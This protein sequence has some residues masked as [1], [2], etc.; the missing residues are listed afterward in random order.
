MP[1]ALAPS[2]RA[3]LVAALVAALL[4]V[5]SLSSP[6]ADGITVSQSYAMPALGTVTFTGHGY[7]HGHGMSQY[8]AE[9]AAR[10]GLTWQQI[11]AFY[12]P[13]TTMAKQSPTVRVLISADTTRDLVV[14]P[15]T[16]LKVQNTASGTLW[17]IPA[18]GATRWRLEVSGSTTVVDYLTDTWH[19]WGSFTGDGA[20]YAGGSAI[21]LYA[22]SVAKR[23]RG[24]LVAAS[25]V[26]G[27]TDRDTVNQ[28]Q[29][30]HYLKGVVPREMPASW[31]PA[32]VRAQA[33][34]ARTYAAYELQ[35]PRA[36]HYQLC[37]TT[38]CQVYGGYD[39]EDARSNDAITQTAG[40]VLMYGGAPAF[41]QFGSSSGGWTSANQFSYLPAKQDPYD[42]WSGNPVRNWTKTVDVATIEKT[43]TAVGDLRGIRFLTRDGNGDWQG[44]VWTMEL[45]GVKNG[46][47]TKVSVSGDSF[48]SKLA[49]RSTY[50]TVGS[51]LAR[52]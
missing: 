31:S 17:S 6:R 10:K 41:T 43:W 29:M 8:G 5:S 36:A 37:D 44:R 24:L 15:R 19:R 47:A 12:Y 13:G 51:T 28:L 11:V 32:A 18:N 7:G 23:Y 1:R 30:D 39:A 20:F 14:G 48:R 9:G 4:T 40:V 3:T 22:G 21:T 52:K 49:L 33:V 35:H 42:N 46:V 27:S 26:K 50:F 25:P 16:G 45:T 2:V 38:S 34:A